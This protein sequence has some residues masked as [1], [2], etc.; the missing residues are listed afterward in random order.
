MQQH[1]DKSSVS[2]TPIAGVIRLVLATSGVRTDPM[3]RSEQTVIAWATPIVR[4]VAKRVFPPRHMEPEDLEQEI[5]LGV[6][7]ALKS[8]DPRRGSLRWW[9][10]RGGLQRAYDAVRWASRHEDEM[11]VAEISEVDHLLSD[12]SGNPEEI[13]L[14]KRRRQRLAHYAAKLV[15]S[16]SDT[17]K[18]VLRELMVGTDG[19]TPEER[20]ASSGLSSEQVGCA[21]TELRAL[22]FAALRQVIAENSLAFAGHRRP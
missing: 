11:A 15:Q 5:W 10:A 6:L 2:P 17:A 9:V 16:A 1:L 19:A 13:I 12:L 22:G 8:Y 14:R 4:E 3:D 18:I 21:R 20:L 7:Q